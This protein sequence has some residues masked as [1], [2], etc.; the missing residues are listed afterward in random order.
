LKLP[1]DFRSQ[2][3][4][5]VNDNAT[6]KLIKSYESIT[7][8]NGKASSIYSSAMTIHSKMSLHAFGSGSTGYSR[9]WR[10][11]IK[12]IRSQINKDI[13]AITP[14][15]SVINDTDFIGVKL[16][17]LVLFLLVSINNTNSIDPSHG[18]KLN[19]PSWTLSIPPTMTQ[20]MHL[21]TF[22]K[23][24]ALAFYICATG[25]LK[26]KRDDARISILPNYDDQLRVI[27]VGEAGIANLM[28]CVV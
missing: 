5:D 27:I 23:K 2:F 14:D 8:D 12:K 16:A 13:L 15:S 10:N 25:L 1:S 7:N 6:I 17:L 18:A 4:Q 26:T 3:L 20:T 19:E 28:F 9:I 24:Q 22:W 11:N 21:W